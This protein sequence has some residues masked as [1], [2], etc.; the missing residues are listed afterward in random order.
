[1]E[2]ERLVVKEGADRN[3]HE[4]GRPG[5]IVWAGEPVWKLLGIADCFWALPRSSGEP[6]ALVLPGGTWQMAQLCHV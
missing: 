5:E 4:P 2:A 3:D 6:K 1:M